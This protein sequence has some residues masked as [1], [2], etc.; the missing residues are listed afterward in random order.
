MVKLDDLKT[1]LRIYHVKQVS[2]KKWKLG[3]FEIIFLDGMVV[4]YGNF[5]YSLAKEICSMPC[6][7]RELFLS[8]NKESLPLEYFLT[9]TFVEKAISYSFSDCF[10][11]GSYEEYSNRYNNYKIEFIKDYIDAGNANELFLKKVFVTN[12]SALHDTLLSIR[13]FYKETPNI[14]SISK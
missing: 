5:P 14:A 1:F 4:I 13:N 9:N 12:I 7:S 6:Y 3:P 2:K 10:L 8:K 11:C